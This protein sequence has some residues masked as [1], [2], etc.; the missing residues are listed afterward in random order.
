MV[1]ESGCSPTSEAK[2]PHV[3]HVTQYMLSM[4]LAWKFATR[5]G[6]C[7]HCK[8]VYKDLGLSN[9]C[10]LILVMMPRLLHQKL[11]SALQGT[12]G[13]GEMVC[14]VWV[15]ICFWPFVRGL[16]RKGKYGIPLSTVLKSGMLA[17]IFTLC[18]GKISL[19]LRW[20]LSHDVWTVCQVWTN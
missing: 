20:E 17:L 7:E 2:W 3:F 4:C 11:P 13:L 5:A 8:W 9:H 18:C 12:T 15:V 10:Q 16:F 1:S 19:P 14:N 6:A